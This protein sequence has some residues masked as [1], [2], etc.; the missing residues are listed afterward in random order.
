M[1]EITVIE[2]SK[3]SVDIGIC[4]YRRPAIAA[5]LLS[6]FEMD[7]PNDVQVRLIVADN[8]AEPSAKAT[9]DR[10][11][12]SS[13][14]DI[15]YVHCPKSN[16]SIARN[17]CLSECTAQYL[18]FIDD[19]ETAPRN[20]LSEL[21]E[22]ARATGAEAVLGPV[23]AI[24]SDGAP[25]WMRKGDFHSTVPVW[26]DGEIITGYT[27]NTLLKMDAPAIK[28]RRFA[29]SLG[30]SGGE[31]THFFS[32]THEAGG[33]IVFAEGAMLS[34]PVPDNRASFM[35]LA[36]RRFRSGQT[37]GRVLADKKPGLRRVVQVAKAA[38]KIIYCGTFALLTGFDA[39]RRNR[40]L[41]RGALHLGSASG[42]FGV[43]EIRQ[44]GT[45]EAT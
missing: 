32:H 29:L 4:T 9:I 25:E 20:W 3:S 17:A 31:D 42:A 11:R 41:L 1:N 16:I 5:T 33:K 12:G 40:Y 6:L 10:L 15:T 26:V 30:Q 24:Y 35:W 21:M 36:K 27:C 45:V 43:R 22:T 39:V 19:D 38:S 18:A 14:F 23:T 44:Y 8:D 7:I 37:H 2:T 34:E 28:G 13:P